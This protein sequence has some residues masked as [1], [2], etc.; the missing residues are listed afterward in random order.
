MKR[1]KWSVLWNRCR[2]VNTVYRNASK[3]K[4]QPACHTP[5]IRAINWRMCRMAKY[6]WRYFWH[7]FLTRTWFACPVVR[8]CVRLRLPRVRQQLLV[9]WQSPWRNSVF[10]WAAVR[11]VHPV[12]AWTVER[13]RSVCQAAHCLPAPLTQNWQKNCMLWREKIYAEIR[14]IRCWDPASIFTGIL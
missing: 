12:F 2:F 8:E 6:L 11:M 13:M 5:V 4:C 7:S 10:L 3:K 9:G 14:W 1:E